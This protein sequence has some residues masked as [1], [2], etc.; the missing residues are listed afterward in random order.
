MRGKGSQRLGRENDNTDS[1]LFK[2]W[3]RYFKVLVWVFRVNKREHKR[4]AIEQETELVF[5][6]RGNI[7]IKLHIIQ[8]IL[9]LKQVHR[10]SDNNSAD[11]HWAVQEF[12]VEEEHKK[13][14]NPWV[15]TGSLEGFNPRWLSAPTSALRKEHNPVAVQDF[16]TVS[17]R[18]AEEQHS[19]GQGAHNQLRD[20]QVLQGGT[21]CVQWDQRLY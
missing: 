9:S 13:P 1:I 6:V 20:Y 3:I 17:N 21:Y 15:I 11:A 8:G 2:R 10:R 14:V 7:G 4:P 12:R 16:K 5:T 18:L 19:C